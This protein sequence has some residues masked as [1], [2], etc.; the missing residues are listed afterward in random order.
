MFR[1]IIFLLLV[2]ALGFGF[3]WFADRPGMVSLVWEGTRYETSLMVALAA[4]VAI[5]VAIMVTWWIVS[6]VLRS[7]L[8]MR[9]FF[10]NRRR[11]RGYHALSQ[12]CWLQAQAMPGAPANWPVTAASSLAANRWSNCWMSRQ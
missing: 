1:L 11:D 8:L 3:A 12:A 7:P 5:V 4:F 2:L 9:R 6:L 10:R